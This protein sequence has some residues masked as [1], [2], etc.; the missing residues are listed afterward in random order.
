[1]KTQ[2]PLNKSKSKF[3]SRAPLNKNAIRLICC[4][5]MTLDIFNNNIRDNHRYT[6]SN[7]DSIVGEISDTEIGMKSHFIQ[8]IEDARMNN[9]I[10]D[11]STI[12][13][14]L[15]F[16]STSAK[17]TN[18]GQKILYGTISNFVYHTMEN[19]EKSREVANTDINM[20]LNNDILEKVKSDG[21]LIYTDFYIVKHDLFEPEF[22][23]NVKHNTILQ[24]VNENLYESSSE[25]YKEYLSLNNQV[26]VYVKFSSSNGKFVLLRSA[27]YDSTTIGTNGF[28]IFES[29]TIDKEMDEMKYTRRVITISGKKHYYIPAVDFV[30]GT[31]HMFV[32]HKYSGDGTHV[33]DEMGVYDVK[34][35]VF[36]K[37]QSVDE[38]NSVVK[39]SA[40]GQNICVV[41]KKIGGTEENPTYEYSITTDCVNNNEHMTGG[42]KYGY[43]H[44][45]NYRKKWIV[46]IR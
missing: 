18:V 33:Y 20:E 23:I 36:Y 5:N 39:L 32:V 4:K 34:T 2:T 24:C 22:L 14:I 12:R 35:K 1:M 28:V 37:S 9:Y 19:I 43:R 30:M 26:K 16:P 40:Q 45:N 27:Y 25:V 21:T 15:K 8:L 10:F 38:T 11:G 41:Y 7:I 17:D 42:R 31:T 3:Y 44:R 46:R 13:M 6:F 29:S